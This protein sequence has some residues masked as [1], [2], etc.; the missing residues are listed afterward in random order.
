MDHRRVVFAVHPHPPS[1]PP[2]SLAALLPWKHTQHTA[3]QR[4]ED[5][6]FV[7]AGSDGHSDGTCRR[8]AESE[9]NIHNIEGCNCYCERRAG[10]VV[11]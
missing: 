1:P 4:R 5:D 9:E 7:S 10:T 11:L 8:A 6:D 2:P 3:V